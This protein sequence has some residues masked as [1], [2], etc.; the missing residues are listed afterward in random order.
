MGNWILFSSPFPR[1]IPTKPESMRPTN[2]P[3]RCWGAVKCAHLCSLPDAVGQG[4]ALMLFSWYYLVGLH[5]HTHQSTPVVNVV[6]CRPSAA[7]KYCVFCS[8][9]VSFFP[10]VVYSGHSVALTPYVRCLGFHFPSLS[11]VAFAE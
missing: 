9:W 10:K 2:V 7:P 11:S 4:S 3:Q 5:T 1:L 6:L 8:F